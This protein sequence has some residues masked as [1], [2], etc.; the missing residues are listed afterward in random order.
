MKIMIHFQTEEKVG[1]YM[2]NLISHC[3]M[4]VITFPYWV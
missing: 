2:I 3:I 4:D 1:E